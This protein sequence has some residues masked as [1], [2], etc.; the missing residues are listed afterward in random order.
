MLEFVY[1]A[2]S[3]AFVFLL[4]SVVGERE[5]KYVLVL[6]AIF[7]GIFTLIGW[8]PPIYASSIFPLLLGM[9]VVN[10]IR[11]QYREKFG[12]S[13]SASSLI[14]KV[15]AFVVFLQFAIVF[16]NGLA[17]FNYTTSIQAVN[18]T[19]TQDYKLENAATVYGDYTNPSSLDQLSIGLTL[20]W[21]SWALTWSM[22]WGIFTIY[23]N[24]VNVFHLDSQ[25]AAVISIGFYL[26][27]AIE[28]FVLLMFRTRPPEM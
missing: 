26:M 16:V 5:V 13:A 21:T 18:N 14:W 7:A 22:I 9:S 4:G 28:V 24:L 8:L 2:I 23:P 25:I 1:T 10:F 15:M 27:M 12:G 20:V 11:D 6:L 19:V 3:L 17:A